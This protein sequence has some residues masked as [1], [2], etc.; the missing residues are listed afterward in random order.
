[1]DNLNI[2]LGFAEKHRPKAAQLYYTA[3]RQ[4]L[5]PIFRDER[6]ALQ[7][8]EQSLNPAYAIAAT[9]NNELV[10]I[11]GFHDKQGNLL[12]IRPSNMTR[13]FGFFG[14]WVRL[15]ALSIFRRT[16]AGCHYRTC[17]STTLRASQVRCGRHQPSRPSTLRA[18][19]LCCHRHPTVSIPETDFWIFRGD[20]DAQNH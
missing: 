4:K 9:L 3:F 6:R 10:G 18:Q 14:G 5:H 2:T 15:L 8:L 11:A 17:S 7:V 12:D 20:H 1:M 13:T 19:R 16:I